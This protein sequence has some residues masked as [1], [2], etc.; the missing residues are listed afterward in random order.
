MALNP[1][2][3]AVYNNLAE[4]YAHH[5]PVKKAFEYYEKAIQLNPEEPLYYHNFGTV[6]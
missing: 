4:I 2:D 1:K 6:V 5:G 3:P